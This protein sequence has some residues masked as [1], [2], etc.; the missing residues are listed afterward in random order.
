M[1]SCGSDAGQGG[2]AELAV[3]SLAAMIDLAE[4]TIPGD[5]SSIAAQ[6]NNPKAAAQQ[7]E[8][9]EI[10]KKQIEQSEACQLDCPTLLQRYQ[11]AVELATGKKDESKLKFFV[12]NANDPCLQACRQKKEYKQGFKE[13]DE[14][15]N[16][17]NSEEIY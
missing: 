1:A 4:A 11:E 8:R 5:S 3:D 13:L 6:A 17:E 10:M 16:G 7:E 15:L 2:H 12:K 9:K 14:A